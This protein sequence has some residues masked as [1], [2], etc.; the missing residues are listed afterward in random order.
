M[1]P[2]T[3][4]RKIERILR[5]ASKVG[6]GYSATLV[7]LA[8]LLEILGLIRAS[9]SLRTLGIALLD[10]KFSRTHG[11]HRHHQDYSNKFASTGAPSRKA[12]LA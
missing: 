11:E 4:T 3:L 1:R 7:G 6:G 2:Y 9:I 5:R 8:L 10:S 12:A